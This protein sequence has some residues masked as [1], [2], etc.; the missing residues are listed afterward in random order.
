M[1]ALGRARRR[2]VLFLFVPGF[3]YLVGVRIVPALFTIYM[4]LTR[5]DLTSGQP[6]RFT[7]LANYAA[8]TGDGGF[9]DALG[10][11]L[12]FMTAATAIELG[13]GLGLAVMVNRDFRGRRLVRTLLLAPMVITPVVVGTM[14]YILFQPQ[15]GPVNYFLSLLGLAPVGWLTSPQ[16]ALVSIIIT[17]VWHWTPFLFLLSL[18]ALQA[19]PLELTEAAAVDGAGPW[20]SFVRITLPV[21]RDTLV[22][23]VVLRAMEAFEIFAEPY[24]MTGGGPGSAT[25]TLSLHIY[26]AAFLYFHMGYTAAM[27]VVSIGI[28]VAFYSLYLELSPQSA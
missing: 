16:V 5:W 27:I 15:I 4:S 28:L 18:A 26:R 8:L 12:L 11:T 25:E 21:I 22:V 7:G 1:S 2:A 19:V 14:W 17:D 20:Q 23:A 13:L 9:L 3:A 10:R 24:V 6:M